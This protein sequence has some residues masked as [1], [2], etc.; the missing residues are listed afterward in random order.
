LSFGKQLMK[1]W[2]LPWKGKRPRQLK[3]ETFAGLRSQ[4]F[5]FKRKSKLALLVSEEHEGRVES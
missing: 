2:K 4:A 1:L 3:E 5:A